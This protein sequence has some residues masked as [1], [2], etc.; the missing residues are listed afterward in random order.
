VNPHLEG[1]AAAVLGSADRAAAVQLADELAAV[2]RLF[3]ENDT[4]RAALID[5]AVPTA[6]R[7]GA[8]HDLLGSRVSAGTTRLA[9]YAAATV[10][11]TEVPAAMAWLAH[12]AGRVAQ[13]AETAVA[14]R[15]FLASRERVSGFAAALYEDLS[16]PELEE[17]EEELFRFGRVIETTPALRA[18]LGDRDLPESVRRGV[19]DDLLAGKVEPATLRLVDY[20]VVAGRARDILGTLWWLVDRTA[21]ARGWRVARVVAARE[22]E[23]AEQASLAETLGRVVGQP[24][25]VQVTID[26]ALLSGV[27]VRIGDLQVD[28]SARGRIEQLREHMALVAWEDRG[29]GPSGAGGAGARPGDGA[30]DRERHEE[31]AN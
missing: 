6:A 20:V 9:S 28:A 1:Y 5:T 19:V 25:E 2:D 11:A 27:R 24:V 10:K 12:R 31:G 18:A 30:S 26:P 23:P 4:L 8:V 16:V 15:S 14:A 29:F 13:G 21:E 17:L 22:V 3:T 7:R